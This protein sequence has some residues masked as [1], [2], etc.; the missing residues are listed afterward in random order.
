MRVRRLLQES[1][2]WNVSKSARSITLCSCT[3]NCRSRANVRQTSRQFATTTAPQAI[4]A[5]E[6]DFQSQRVPDGEPPLKARIVPA[7]PSYF[8]GKPDFT[9]NLLTLQALLRKYQT[10][11]VVEPL[12]APRTA[13]RTLAQYRLLVGEPVKAAKYHKIVQ[14][15]H[16]LNQIYPSLMPDEVRKAMEPYMRAT[17]PHANVARPR[18]IDG[19]GRAVGLGRRKTSSAR[20]WLVEGDG[21]ILVNGKS[22][23]ATFPRVHD[24]ESA[25]WALKATDRIDKYNVWGLVGGGG[26]TGQAESLTLAV[27][28]AL[29][30][31]EPSLKPSLRR[32]GCVTRNPKRV[33]RKKPGKLKA[34]KMP[35]WVKR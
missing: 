29:L 4:A 31:H 6:I 26:L 7:S 12:D 33:E 32:A 34:R 1:R 28:R 17:N 13:W 2:Y 16:R 25:V 24:R 10:Y 20:V 19:F 18:T 22:L 8:T 27:A 14:I 11:P 15:L 9:D 3:S 21:E 23:V 5:A 35:A 30:V